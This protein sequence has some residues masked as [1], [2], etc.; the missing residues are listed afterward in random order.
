MFVQYEHRVEVDLLTFFYSSIQNEE[1]LGQRE[2]REQVTLSD[3]LADND[4]DKNALYSGEWLVGT[5]IR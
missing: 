4:E 2:K 1:I 3:D 5:D